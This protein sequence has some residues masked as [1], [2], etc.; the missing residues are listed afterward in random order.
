MKLRKPLS[1]VPDQLCVPLETIGIARA[2]EKPVR[3]STIDRY[4]LFYVAE[5]SF[6]PSLEED[7][8]IIRYTYEM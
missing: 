5:V 3:A 2:R 6:D 1:G 7:T 8:F 4:L